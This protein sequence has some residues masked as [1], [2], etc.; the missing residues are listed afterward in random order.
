MLWPQRGKRTNICF[1]NTNNYI[2]GKW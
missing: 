1:N 2:S